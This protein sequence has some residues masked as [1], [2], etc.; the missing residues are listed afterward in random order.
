MADTKR[1][2]RVFLCHASVDKPI[3]QELYHQLVRDEIDIWPDTKKLILA[4]DW[5]IEWKI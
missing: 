5:E 3:V 1:A 4:Q 2:L